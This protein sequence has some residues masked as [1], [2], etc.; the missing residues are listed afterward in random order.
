M[1]D[2]ECQKFTSRLV[3]LIT[4]KTDHK[5]LWGLFSKSF[6]FQ[7]CSIPTR[8]CCDTF[9]VVVAV[10][11]MMMWALDFD[12]VEEVDEVVVARRLE[13]RLIC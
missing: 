3:L 10:V 7:N 11:M 5:L 1:A 13:M 2:G 6:R 12:A 4:T 8:L 9:I